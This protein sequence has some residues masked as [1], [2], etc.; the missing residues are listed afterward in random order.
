[1]ACRQPPTPRC[2]YR[3]YRPE[4]VT[5]H[6]LFSDWS[7]E[8]WPGFYEQFYELVDRFPDHN[9]KSRLIV[10]PTVGKRVTWRYKFAHVQRGKSTCVKAIKS[11]KNVWGLESGRCFGN[12]KKS[13]RFLENTIIFKVENRAGIWGTSKNRAGFWRTLWLT[14]D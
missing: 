10:L 9:I 12:I 6:V 4:C 11:Y 7:D 8:K 14:K 13:D 2:G 3:F 1:M 5:C